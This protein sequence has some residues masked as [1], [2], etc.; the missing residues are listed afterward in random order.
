LREDWIKENTVAPEQDRFASA[1]E[2]IE[3][4]TET[5]RGESV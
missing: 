4:N 5:F 1:E 3:F 2:V